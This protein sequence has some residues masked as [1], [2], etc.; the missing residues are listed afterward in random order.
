MCYWWMLV[1][2]GIRLSLGSARVKCEAWHFFDS[3]TDVLNNS[4]ELFGCMCTFQSGL[5]VSFCTILFCSDYVILN[6]V[7]EEK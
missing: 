1:G 4:S 2:P 3:V 5:F 7:L 6:F